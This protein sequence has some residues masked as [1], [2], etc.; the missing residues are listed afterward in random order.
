MTGQPHA[1]ASR[2]AIRPS[3]GYTVRVGASPRKRG[4]AL[5]KEVIMG[6]KNKQPKEPK[7]KAQKT[8]L[9]KRKEKRE[10]AASKHEE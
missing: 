1:S 7:K 8:L 5:P 4:A 3:W 2:F 10:K 9:E 6:E